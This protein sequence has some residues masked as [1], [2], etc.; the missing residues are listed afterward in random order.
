M[1]ERIGLWQRPPEIDLRRGMHV[2]LLPETHAA[3]RL[4]CVKRGI[5]VQELI[6]ELLQRAIIDDPSIMSIV[7]DLVTRKKERYFK[8]LSTTDAESL[9]DIIEAESPL[10]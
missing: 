6:E 7:D 2:K 10:K 9:F 8:K 4:L 1:T 3:V 5:S